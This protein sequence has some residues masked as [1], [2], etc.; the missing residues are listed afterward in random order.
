MKILRYSSLALAAL[1]FSACQDV[2]EQVPQGGA[3]TDEQVKETNS[4]LPTRT[5][6]A[7]S[8]MFTM[9]GEP[10]GCLH[11]SS[12]RPD[13][14][15]FVMMALSNDL[16]ASDAWIA[17][18]GYNW[19]ST[20]GEWSSRNPDY[21]NPYIRYI[22]PYK[23]IRLA[24]DVISNYPADTQNE[25]ELNRIAQAR[26]VRAFDY[27]SLAPSFQFNYVDHLEA[28]CVPIV[29]EK[30]VE[31]DNNPRATVKEVYELIMSDLNYACK[32][33]ENY[34]PTNKNEISGAVAYGLRA[35][36]NLAMEKWAEAAA[37]AQKAIDLSGVKPASIA[38]V[39]K[40]TF[41][42]ISEKN[43]LWGYDMTEDMAKK[44]AY[45]TCDAWIC[46]FSGDGYSAATGC[47]VHIN[48]LLYDLI[49]P[50][51]V[52]KGWWL[53]KNGKSPL[54]NTVSWKN[55]DGVSFTGDALVKLA[56][57]NVKVAFDAY[58][59]VKFGCQAGVGTTTN[60]SDWPLMRVEE[61][62]LIVAEGLAKSGDE[63]TAKQVLSNFITT[64]RDPAY[65]I[66][67]Q[68]GKRNLADEIW[69]QRRIELW[70]E[71]FGMS[72]IMRLKK[73]IVRFH[74]EKDPY[75]DA[76][77]FNVAYGDPYMLLRFPTTETDN[78][79]GIKNNEGGQQ[80]T[81]GQNKELLDGVTD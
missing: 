67:V 33:L 4:A 71:G 41:C 22:A 42:N 72:D 80:P 66:A 14:Y 31:A 15:G 44:F 69:L 37:D 60:C 24:N 43:W 2:N 74:S 79:H 55:E 61:M 57:T 64:Y 50:S 32:I 47:C 56:I 16:E 7:F 3:L 52:R 62:Y 70:G 35:R 77:R 48:K 40:P 6:A 20:C 23:Q 73:N 51:D 9:M 36:A 46:S 1:T 8:A 78:N 59:N 75:P 38:D 26:A 68:L 81:P 28:P 63:N 65:N 49:N 18:N 45:A 29:T 30:G 58:T 76:F 12:G 13:D 34:K 5:E 21:A 19:F 39:S 25:K 11:N 10:N 17:D 54:T 53:N 27:M